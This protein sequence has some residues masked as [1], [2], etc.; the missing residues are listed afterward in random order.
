[1]GG[2]Q[3]EKA[4]LR[5]NEKHLDIIRADFPLYSYGEQSLWKGTCGIILR[6]KARVRAD[7][8]GRFEPGLDLGIAIHREGLTHTTRPMEQSCQNPQ[9]HCK[10]ICAVHW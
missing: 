6:Y 1:M 2:V 3:H 8:R 5:H 9:C 7:K 10:T 4:H